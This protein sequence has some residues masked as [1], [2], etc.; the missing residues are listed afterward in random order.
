MSRTFI[1]YVLRVFTLDVCLTE[2][3]FKIERGA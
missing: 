3:Q 2:A 1:N